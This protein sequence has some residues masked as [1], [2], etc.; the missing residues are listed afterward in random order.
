MRLLRHGPA[1]QE[2]AGLVDTNGVIRDLSGHVSDIDRQVLSPRALAGLAAIPTHT[3]PEIDP[4][5]RV[6]PPV[7][8][9]GKI[10]AIGLNFT[11]HAEESGM[12]LPVEPIIFIK[13]VAATGANDP[14]VI[15]KGASKTDWEVELGLLIGARA[16]HVEEQDAL[17]HV[18]GYCICNDVSERQFQLE[19]T[20]QWTKGKSCDSFAP[21]GPWLVTRD[22]VPD[23]QN[24]GMWLEVNGRR[25]QDS[26]TSRMVFGAAALVSYV[27]RFMTLY[28]GDLIETGTP[29]GVGMGQKPES[30]YLRAGD[31]LRLGI[32]GLGEQRQKCIDWA[33]EQ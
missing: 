32:E 3:L 18:A 12:A 1:G 20:G 9:I 10:V 8:D 15:P 21:V 24:L 23:V 4:A 6:G 29:A 22:E 33:G 5:V 11:D 28:P 31:E 16:Q 26:S 7:A 2:K 30:V 27:S 13:A 14:I 17:E 19:G 25:Y